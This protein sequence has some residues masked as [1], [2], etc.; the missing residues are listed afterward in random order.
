MFYAGC[1][2]VCPYGVKGIFCNWRPAIA[3][4][5][6]CTFEQCK[7]YA[8]KSDSYGFSYAGD[9][10]IC[11]LCD[12]TQVT[13]LF[14]HLVYNWGVYVRNTIGTHLN[15]LCNV[16]GILRKIKELEQFSVFCATY[17][18]FPTSSGKD[19]QEK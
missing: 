2:N 19:V 7:E 1:E 4:C 14:G 17:R 8:E 12:E 13:I 18:F 11:N 9:Q 16:K 10:E 15:I 3:V 5:K 6:G